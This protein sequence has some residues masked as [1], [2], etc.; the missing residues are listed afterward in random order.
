MIDYET[1]RAKHDKAFK[2]FDLIRKAYRD[3]QIDDSE[4]LKAKEA[5]GIATKEFDKAYAI[6]ANN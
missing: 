3:R 4:F 1:A 5:Y 2:A 6:A